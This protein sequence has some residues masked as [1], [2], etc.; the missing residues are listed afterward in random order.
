MIPGVVTHPAA[1]PSIL[2]HK[3]WHKVSHCPLFSLFVHENTSGR[4]LRSHCGD[5]RRFAALMWAT[6]DCRNILGGTIFCMCWLSCCVVHFSQLST[7]S[8]WD[9]MFFHCPSGDDWLCVFPGR[10]ES[11]PDGHVSCNKALRWG[12]QVSTE[13]P[14]PG[15]LDSQSPSYPRSSSVESLC[16]SRRTLQNPIRICESWCP[17]TS[18]KRS[19][20][21]SVPPPLI[22]LW[23][24]L[25]M[26]PP[27]PSYSA[28]SCGLPHP[29][30]A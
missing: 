8:P 1:S 12:V 15:W 28:P 26:V 27:S 17:L 6:A 14:R 11:E 4:Q 3:R 18:P 23:G 5:H 29:L 7:D 10:C 22:K 13:H 9:S 30:L 20:N 21:V 24:L 25:S 16:G 2:L 19:S